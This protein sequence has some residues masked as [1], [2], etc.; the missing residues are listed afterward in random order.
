MMKLFVIIS[1]AFLLQCNV[2]IGQEKWKFSFG[3]TNKES[4]F[5][6]IVSNEAYNEKRGFG[7]DFVN[8]DKVKIHSKKNGFCSSDVPF[9]F[10]A[11][12][13]EG[14][15]EVLITF[16]AKKHASETTVKAESKRLMLRKIKTAKGQEITKSITINV[17]STKIEDSRSI[18]LKSRSVGYL[19]W[20]NKLTLEFSGKHPAI[21]SIE[22]RPKEDYTTLFLAGNSTVTDQ[23]GSPYASWGQMIT[24]YVTNDLS[25]ANYAE[26]GAS[27]ASFKSSNRL[28]K[29]LSMMKED[30]YLFIEFGHNDQKRKGEGI[31][32]WTSFTDLLTEFI[33]RT[34]DKGGIPVLVTPTQRRSFNKKGVIKHTHKEY[35]D[36]MRKVAKD[37]NVPLIDIHA[38]TKILYETW[39]VD[40]S[41]NAFV[42]YP[43]NTFP[44]Q[45]KILKD[46]S[47]FN[48]FGANEVALC[49]M[50]GI[51]EQDISIKRFMV[52]SDFSYSPT[53]PNSFKE[54]DLLMSPRYRNTKPKGN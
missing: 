30:D 44:G 16:G 4:G 33:T 38:M 39:G 9:Y 46:N 12:V 1:I 24:S 42:H 15:Y 27:L 11:K 18:R 41:K 32:P 52:D 19:N 26:S 29:V 37:M 40:E 53:F 5:V 3:N 22:I 13:P 8:I 21:K 36:A 50:K 48:E 25:V 14:T 6:N 7:F 45:E 31:G 47:H 35:P 2:L 51:I 20:D 54:W 43:A 10:S 49:I 17:R 23:D 34:R 28:D